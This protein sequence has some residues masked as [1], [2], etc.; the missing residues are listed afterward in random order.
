MDLPAD[1]CQQTGEG[2]FLSGNARVYGPDSTVAIVEASLD[3]PDGPLPLGGC[4]RCNAWRG[5]HYLTRPD[6]EFDFGICLERIPLPQGAR[7]RLSARY[8]FGAPGGGF[9]FIS[10]VVAETT[11]AVPYPPDRFE[12]PRFPVLSIT[13]HPI[14]RDGNGRFEGIEIRAIVISHCPEVREFLFS[15]RSGQ[16]WLASSQKTGVY[17]PAGTLRFLIDADWIRRDGSDG[18]FEITIGESQ[19]LT[20]MRT[21]IP[22]PDESEDYTIVEGSTRLVRLEPR[23]KDRAKVFRTRS[24]RVDEFESRGSP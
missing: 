3:H 8:G 4:C 17:P 7:V 11:L 21:G 2:F 9:T 24:Y 13:E 14:D 6:T 18:P 5:I 1:S 23:F 12:Y 15:C 22:D 20:A 16:G 19:D 10:P